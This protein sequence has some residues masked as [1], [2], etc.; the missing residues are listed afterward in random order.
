MSADRKISRRAFAGGLAL[1][2][3]GSA[4]AGAGLCRA[5]QQS[6]RLSQSHARKNLR[7]PGR[8]RPA[9]GF[10][11]RMVVRDGEPHRQRRR[12]LWRAMDAVP[13]GAGAGRAAGGLGQPADLDGACG[14]DPRRHPSTSETFA[15][16]G[17]G[18]AGVTIEPFAAWIDSWAMRGVGSDSMPT[19]SRRSISPHPARISPMRSISKPIVRSCCKATAATAR[20][21]SASRRHIITASPS[22]RFP[23]TSPSTTSKSPSRGR[24]GWTGNGAASRWRRTKPAGTGSR[25]IL[26]SGEKLMLYRMRQKDGHNYA[27]GTW[28]LPDAT[29]R[30][31]APADIQMTPKAPIDIE[32]HKLPVA[33]QVA[34]PVAPACDRN[35]AAQ[36]EGL[37]GHELCLLGRPDQLSRQPCRRG[38]SG[39]DG[40]LIHPALRPTT[41]LARA[42]PGETMRRRE[43][44][45]LLGGTALAAPR[46]GHGRRTQRS[47][48]ASR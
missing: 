38:L 42:A 22:S 45:A 3:L 40:L 32:G 18:Q 1:L 9:S 17:V 20:N 28:I 47:R 27:S 2:G 14:G 46:I 7:V 23:A 8:S 4:G 43:F 34:I 13:A 15:R 33:W 29:T 24:P 5:R 10:P 16:G 12:G 36:S 19:P 35:H 26:P 6:G 30:Q 31:L 21:P 11:H 48:S 41:Y 37:D 25:C 39:A 44:M